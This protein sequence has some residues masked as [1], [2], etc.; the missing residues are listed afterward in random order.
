[1]NDPTWIDPEERAYP[2]GGFTRKGRALIRQNPHNPAVLPYGEVRAIRCS[3][4]DTYFTIPARLRVK[5]V[6]IKGY[7]HSD[8]AEYGV[9]YTF[10]PDAD[11]AHCTTCQPGAGCRS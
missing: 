9:Q 10:T 3:I 11:P 2:Y 6:V 8:P 4:P 7:L 5:G 1:M